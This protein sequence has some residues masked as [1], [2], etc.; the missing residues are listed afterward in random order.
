MAG[1][2]LYDPRKQVFRT[3]VP[4]TEADLPREELLLINILI[5]L[6]V[7]AHYLQLSNPGSEEVS[8]IRNDTVANF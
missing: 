7:L 2:S 1:I 8:N 6:K 5:E 4:P 3:Y